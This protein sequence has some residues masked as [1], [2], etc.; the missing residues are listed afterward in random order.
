MLRAQAVYQ[1]SDINLAA[2]VI[3]EVV[4][5]RYEADSHFSMAN[6][7]QKNYAFLTRKTVWLS[8]V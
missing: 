1:V 8:V 6:K 2:A 3:R 7:N 4:A 5:G